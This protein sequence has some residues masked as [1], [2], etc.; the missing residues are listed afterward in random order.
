MCGIV[1][2]GGWAQRSLILAVASDGSR[3]HVLH[4]GSI[5][6]RLFTAFLLSLPY[7]PGT[8]VILDNV[9]FHKGLVPFVAKG[10]EQLRTPP[11]SP[12]DNCPVENAFSKIKG[13]FRSMW[14]WPAGVDA[15]VDAATRGLDQS[16]V[17]GSFAHLHKR[18]RGA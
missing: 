3:H 1:D 11:Y 17:L 7:P 15:S 18:C 6:K 2:D 5:N 12:E 14:P 16:D 8:V 4:R 13:R 10:F 9:A